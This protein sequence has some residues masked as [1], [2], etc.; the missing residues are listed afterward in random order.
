MAVLPSN[1]PRTPDDIRVV[2]EIKLLQSQIHRWAETHDLWHDC[3]FRD[4]L[5]HVGGEPQDPPVVTMLA[6]EGGLYHVLSGEDSEGLEP[7]FRELLERLGYWYENRDGVSIEIY[8]ID[9]D[10]ASAFA[11]YNHWQWVCSL[12]EQDF[13]DVYQ[14]LFDHFARRPEDLTRLHWRDFE[15]LL[16][17]IFQTQGFEVELGPGGGDDGV[18]LKLLQRDPIGDV[19]T[20]VQAKK[21]AP[22]NKIQQQAV[23]ALYGVSTATGAQKSLFVTTSTY[24]PVARRFAERVPEQLTLATSDDVVEW[25]K[26]ASAGIIADKSTLI[27]P[28][29]VRRILRE[30][31]SR[32]DSRVVHASGG[33][34][35]TIN[36]FALVV[37]E[38]KHAALLMK[39]ESRSISD[40]GFGQVGMEV[41]LLD[42]LSP[43]LN[44]ESVWRA[45]RSVRD[46]VVQY[47]DGKNLYQ[48]WDG[49]PCRFDYVD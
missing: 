20:L 25:C 35:M 41:P 45:R 11:S 32:P 21:Y 30:A 1:A 12:V 43:K 22:K 39:L 34:N 13:A 18:D 46:G 47:W 23:A 29:Q 48:R 14:E 4:H 27:M 36:H 6:F 15:I 19:L 7:Q 2:E 8:A 17:R 49:N 3:A 40:D 44:A 5:R 37:K 24:A 42:D 33:R 16:A 38:A 31:S 26:S 9:P 28:G 10:R